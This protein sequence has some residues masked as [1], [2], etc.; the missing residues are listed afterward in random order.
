MFNLNAVEKSHLDNL[1]SAKFNV[2]ELVEQMGMEDEPQVHEHYLWLLIMHMFHNLDLVNT[3]KIP[4][5]N[6]YRHVHPLLNFIQKNPK[7]ISP[8][9][10]LR[11]IGFNRK[12]T[13][14][15]TKGEQLTLIL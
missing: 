11:T 14:R 10:D 2:L 8:V 6:L 1:G 5:H 3:F 7:T 13:E 4:E 15:W 9:P 12:R